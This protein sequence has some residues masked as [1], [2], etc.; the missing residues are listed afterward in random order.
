MIHPDQQQTHKNSTHDGENLPEDEILFAY[1]K[2]SRQNFILGHPNFQVPVEALTQSAHFKKHCFVLRN[3]WFYFEEPQSRTLEVSNPYF[4]GILGAPN[5][6]QNHNK[7]PLA[8]GRELV[9]LM[10]CSSLETD[11]IN[12]C[13]RC[14]GFLK[15]SSEAITHWSSW[16]H[17]THPFQ[18]PG[19]PQE[20]LRS[21][22]DVS[23]FQK[24]RVLTNLA[25]NCTPYKQQAL[26]CQQGGHFTIQLTELSSLFHCTV[27]PIQKQLQSS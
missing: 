4:W 8:G 12:Y 6:L 16:I 5:K 26:P 18:K 9:M 24:C 3:C 14:R 11:I 17:F 2:S 1:T 21:P 22:S 19:C 27:E 10:V 13:P 7:N 20:F 15:T 25:A 23:H